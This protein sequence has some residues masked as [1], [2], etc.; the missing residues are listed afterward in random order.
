MNL[1]VVPLHQDLAHVA[2]LGIGHVERNGH[3]YVRGLG[4]LSEGERME[5]LVMHGE[6]YAE[7]EGLVALD[8]REGAIYVGSL[9]VAGLGVGM[10][11]DVEAMR[12]LE[13]WD[14][15]SLA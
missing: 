7:R 6:L 8:V 11:V 12:A 4:H 2:A 5:C 13:D 9:Q 10:D 15:G 3:H 14:F 1:P